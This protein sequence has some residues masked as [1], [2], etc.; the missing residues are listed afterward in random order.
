MAESAI[1]C[2]TLADVHPA[3]PR[4]RARAGRRVILVLVAIVVALGATSMLGVHTS[5]AT[6]RAQGY[7]LRVDY[8][9]IARSGLD[10][11]WRVTLTHPGGFG[12]GPIEL[13]VSVRYFDIFEH[14]A[15]YPEPSKSTSDGEMLYL[16]FDPPPGEVFSLDFDAY[17]QPSSQL[18]RRG[19]V[20]VMDGQ[21]VLV[22]TTF[23]T[24]L[25]P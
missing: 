23:R 8:P 17:I 15:F 10:V 19:T 13:A 3:H 14:Q 22:S 2:S 4:L 11:L 24:W 16:E 1:P 6:A 12:S 21:Q 9:R 20:A 7:E 25:I 5:T 18:G